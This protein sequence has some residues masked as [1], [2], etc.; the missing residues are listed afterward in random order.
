MVKAELLSIIRSCMRPY[1]GRPRDPE[2]D[3]A[4][5]LRAQEPRPSWRQIVKLLY[6]ESAAW[7]RTRIQDTA[8]RIASAL[9]KRRARQR[10]KALQ[11]VTEMTGKPEISSNRS[12]FPDSPPAAKIAA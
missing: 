7:S 1:P 11:M 9:R 3:R 6:P 10:E 2:I 12:D 4:A 8:R 5:A